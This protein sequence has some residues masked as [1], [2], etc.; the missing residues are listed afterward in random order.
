MKVD[1]DQLLRP[2]I[3]V[4]SAKRDLLAMPVDVI[5]DFG[6]GI[7]QAQ[8]GEYPDIGK[9]LSG[10]GGASVVELSEI[11]KAIHIELFIQCGL[12]K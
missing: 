7:Y 10:F 2:V 3:W 6:F 9:T 4:A 12:L 5:D 8:I 1:D 11:I